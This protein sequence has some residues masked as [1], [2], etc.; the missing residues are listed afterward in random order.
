MN[1]SN[2]QGS[3]K[4]DEETD[5]AEETD[6]AEELVRQANWST[7]FDAYATKGKGDIPKLLK[8]IMG[9]LEIANHS[10]MKVSFFLR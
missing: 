8:E 2:S 3:E 7:G 9:G 10:S 4:N 5:E 6:V 1:D